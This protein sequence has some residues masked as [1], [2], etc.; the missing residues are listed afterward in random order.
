MASFDG[1][2][3]T[4][5][6]YSNNSSATLHDYS[7]SKIAYFAHRTKR[8]HGHNWQCTSGRAESDILKEF[9]GK[10]KIDGFV[11]YELVADRDSSVNAIFVVISRKAHV[12]TVPTTVLNASQELGSCKQCRATGFRGKRMSETLLAHCKAALSSFIAS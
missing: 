7:T 6:H 8:R 9:L 2:Y 3:L 10:A 1:F 11:I 5:G 12:H 4:R